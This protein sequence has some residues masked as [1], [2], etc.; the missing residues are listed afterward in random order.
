M[1][2]ILSINTKDL[3]G[4]PLKNA[5]ITIRLLER[6]IDRELLSAKTSDTSVV[7]TTRVELT[8]DNAG[9]A[10]TNLT[11]TQDI[12]TPTRYKISIGSV[13]KYFQMPRKDSNLSELLDGD[14]LVPDTPTPP[15]GDQNRRLFAQYSADNSAWDDTLA[16]GD[17]YIRF[18]LAQSKPGDASSLWSVGIKFVGEG[19]GGG[20]GGRGAKGDDGDSV[21][22][23]FSADGTTA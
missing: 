12:I 19:S 10:S 1:A 2:N 23:S 7:V 3:T 5:K 18:A 16:D 6:S 4:S 17:L 21:F 15:V 8:T 20:T 14:D 22:I 11:P 13:Q 9:T